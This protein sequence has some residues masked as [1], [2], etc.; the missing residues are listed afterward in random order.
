MKILFL[1]VANSARS[2]M[3]EGLAK[4]LFGTY[5]EIQSAGS[6]PSGMVNPLAIEAMKE[7]DID[8]AHH[9]SKSW[10]DL[11]P[12]FFVDLDYVIS[13]CAE[14]ICPT[15]TS[16]AKRLRWGL[17]DP[18]SIKGTDAD[19]L[20]AFRRAR[21]EIRSKLEVLRNEL[22]TVAGRSL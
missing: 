18:A 17:P 22:A 12:R 5:V 19:K 1:C 4:N 10:D 14:E 20:E 2:Q 9:R 16:K 6:Y 21:D 8:I 13:L 3:A 15:I 7:I 11:S